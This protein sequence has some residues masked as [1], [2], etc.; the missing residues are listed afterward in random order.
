M[1]HCDL[2]LAT[3]VGFVINLMRLGGDLG[4]SI[5]LKDVTEKS[6]G[7]LKVS[8]VSVDL[9]DLLGSGGVFL[10]WIKTL[11]N[12]NGVSPSETSQNTRDGTPLAPYPTGKMPRLPRNVGSTCCFMPVAPRYIGAGR[13]AVVAAAQGCC[14]ST[15]RPQE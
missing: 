2:S 6:R 1:Y 13:R 9:L 4:N 3:S 15:H 5:Y 10:F 7:V 12:P 8:V 11:M 14:S